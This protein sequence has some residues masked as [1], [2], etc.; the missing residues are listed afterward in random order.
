MVF[1]AL[2]Q[3]ILQGILCRRENITFKYA[4]ANCL[5]SYATTSA[6]RGREN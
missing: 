1:E 6:K 3:F 2:Y 5:F 4:M